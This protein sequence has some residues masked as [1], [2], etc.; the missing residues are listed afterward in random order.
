MAK[1]NNIAGKDFSVPSRMA[2]AQRKDV[3]ELDGE[4]Y[5]LPIPV[6]QNVSI[7]VPRICWN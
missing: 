1:N 7:V 3:E 2:G 5:L 6:L 4:L